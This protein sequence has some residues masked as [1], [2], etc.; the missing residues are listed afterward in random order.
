MK[1]G[2]VS[3]GLIGGSIFKKLSK[4][5]NA[6]GLYAV[7]K[8]ESTIIKAKKYSPNISNDLNYIK[9]CDVI[10][11]ACP[12]NKTIEILDKLEEIVSDEC[13]VLDCASVKEFV[14]QKK[15]RYKFIGS[16][17]M[18]GTEFSGFDYSFESLYEG[19]KWVLTPADNVVETD[20]YKVKKIIE[21]MGA[22]TIITT[23]KEHDEAVA[24]ISHLPLLIAQSLFYGIK[25]NK[26]ACQLASSGFRDMTRLAL[27]N[28]EMAQD[29]R[30]YNEKNIDIAIQKLINSI[31]LLKNTKDLEIFADIKNTRSK[32]YSVEGKNIFN[33]IQD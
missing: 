19:A 14:M 15:R 11:T 7:T 32:M 5:I 24:L 3:L 30:L 33:P 6:N 16:H 4:V 1:I 31:N 25:D 17:P 2:V 8:N 29:M 21:M 13:I 26:L 23:A 12:I 27:S 22:K 20:I 10:F 18:A 9:D 28:L